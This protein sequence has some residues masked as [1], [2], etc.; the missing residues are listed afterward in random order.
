MLYGWVAGYGD[1]DGKAGN[2]VENGKNSGNAA[3]NPTKGKKSK[4]G[5][6]V[7]ATEEAPSKKVEPPAVLTAAEGRSSLVALAA[8]RGLTRTQFEERLGKVKE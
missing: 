8:Q 3:G 4:K 1:D 6:A 2:N 7:A 5:S